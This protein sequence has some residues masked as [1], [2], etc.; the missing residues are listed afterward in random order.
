MST[1]ISAE[2]ARQKTKLANQQ[3]EVVA[4]IR[5]EKKKKALALKKKRAKAQALVDEGWSAQKFRLIDAAVDGKKEIDLESPIYRFHSLLEL[6]FRFIE[7]G[8]VKYQEAHFDWFDLNYLNEYANFD[9]I[10]DEFQDAESRLIKRI[11]KLKGKIDNILAQFKRYSYR[12]VERYYGSREFNSILNQEMQKAIE[13]HS[14]L[15]TRDHVM[16]ANVSNVRKDNYEKY[17]L[18]MEAPL[19]AYRVLSENLRIGVPKP[20]MHNGVY[21]FDLFDRKI[22]VIKGPTLSKD[23]R[24][25]EN[26]FKVSWRLKIQE[27]FPDVELFTAEGLAWLSQTVGQRLIDGV[28]LSLENAAEKGRQKLNLKFQILTDDRDWYFVRSAREK[29]LCCSPDDLVEII[30]RRGFTVDDTHATDDSYGIDVSW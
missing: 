3:A 8:W 11:E 19:N 22:D 12:D 25:D 2:E 5:A 7:I 1:R 4:N 26:I 6:K 30:Q 27:R 21:F 14:T 18:R 23:W 24:S 9:L 20:K 17:F 16:W 10:D 15:F 13:S 29:L 28:F